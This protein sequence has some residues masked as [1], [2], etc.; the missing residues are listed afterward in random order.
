MRARVCERASVCVCV[1]LARSR[2]VC[3]CVCFVKLLNLFSP[4]VHGIL[5]IG[6]TVQC[7]KHIMRHNPQNSS[8]MARQH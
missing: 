3:V 8:L 4:F 5:M 6:F 2:C 1:R 7:S